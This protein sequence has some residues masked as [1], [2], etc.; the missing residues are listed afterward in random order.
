MYTLYYSP[1]A[2]SFCVHTALIETGADYTLQHMD[3]EAGQQRDAAYLA[4]NPNG[5]V[6]TLL[7]DGVAR[8]EAAALLILLADRHP[9]CRTG[10]R[11]GRARRVVSMASAFDQQR[12]AD[13]PLAVVSERC[14]GHGGSPGGSQ[15]RGGEKTRSCMAAHRCA[16]ASAR[17]LRARRR[18]FCCGHLPH[19]ADALVAPHAQ[20]GN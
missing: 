5:V 13:A 7:I 11:S 17:S 20:T 4:L 6:P 1:G 3:L 2:A 18:I 16:S 19:H 14:S 9:G 10:A 8:T 12:A 15:G